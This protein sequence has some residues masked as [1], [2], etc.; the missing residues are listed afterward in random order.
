MD[1]FF[2]ALEKYIIPHWPWITF[3]AIAAMLGQWFKTNIFTKERALV[4]STSRR[5]FHYVT[6]YWGRRSMPLHPMFLG[7][8]LGYFWLPEGLEPLASNFYFAVA[9]MCSLWFFEAI[10]RVLKAKGVEF[11]PTPWEDR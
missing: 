7:F 3:S 11:N 5:R 9:G 8:F 10:T 2:D 1:T 4:Y 6:F